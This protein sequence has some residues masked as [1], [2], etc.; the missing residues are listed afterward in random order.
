VTVIARGSRIAIASFRTP[1]EP[2]PIFL[3]G[4]RRT[5]LAGAIH[6]RMEVLSSALLRFEQEWPVAA[7]SIEYVSIVSTL[8]GKHA[9]DLAMTET[10]VFLGEV[11]SRVYLTRMFLTDSR[12]DQMLMDWHLRGDITSHTP[13]GLF[14]HEAGHVLLNTLVLRAEPRSRSGDAAARLVIQRA[15]GSSTTVAF[16]VAAAKLSRRAEMSPEECVAESVADFYLRGHN[17]C[18]IVSRNIVL[19]LAELWDNRANI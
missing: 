19:A 1:S 10:K 8:P 17:D 18:N 3:T 7:T 12:L 15:I 5:R 4:T 11:F 13:E 2:T 9:D 6:E 16:K 14:W